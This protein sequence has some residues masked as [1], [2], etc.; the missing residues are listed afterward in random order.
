M[1][2]VV[3]IKSELTKQIFDQNAHLYRRDV[4]KIVN[5]MLEA[6]IAALARGDRVEIRGFGAFLGPEQSGAGWSQ[7]LGAV[8]SWPS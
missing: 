2:G 3:M 6:I 5:S 7:P 8:P 4:E 1:A